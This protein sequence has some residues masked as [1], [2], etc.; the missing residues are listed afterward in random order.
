M[1]RSPRLSLSGGTSSI[2]FTDPSA[3][4]EKLNLYRARI[5]D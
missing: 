3:T 5:L 1:S 4:A 2:P